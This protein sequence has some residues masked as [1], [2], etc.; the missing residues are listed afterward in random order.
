MFLRS[1][2]SGLKLTFS[3]NPSHCRL[4]ELLFPLRISLKRLRTWKRADL[5]HRSRSNSS[6]VDDSGTRWMRLALD[7]RNKRSE[8]LM[9]RQAMD[10]DWR[11]TG[12]TGRPDSWQ[13]NSLLDR[14][15][16]T[17][18]SLTSRPLLPPAE[19]NG[20]SSSSAS[21][22]FFALDSISGKGV[23][24]IFHWGQD[25]RVENQ[26]RTSEGRQR[27]VVLG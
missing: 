22:W 10:I 13:I 12:G 8:R 14:A 24:K 21:D 23:S 5:A 4:L 19:L 1:F 25:R 7:W 20:T 27:G 15:R 6:V 3:T 16:H 9:T 18:G 26:G 2:A 17:A 11:T